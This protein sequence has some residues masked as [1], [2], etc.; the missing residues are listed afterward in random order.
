MPQALSQTSLDALVETYDG[1]LIDAYGVLVDK[2]SAMP[3]ARD[4]LARLDA[5][6]RPWLVV[7]NSASRLP[8][9]LRTQRGIRKIPAQVRRPIGEWTL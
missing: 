2:N 8:E 1:F 9:T 3:G 5:A 4:L 6:G 7:T